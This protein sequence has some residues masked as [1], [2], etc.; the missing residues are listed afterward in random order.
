MLDAALIKECSDRSLKPA[1]VEQFINAAGSK[2]PLA[3]TVKAGS[4]LILFPK[5]KT[6]EEALGIIRENVGHAVVR[7]GLTQLPAGVGLNDPAQLQ[8]DLV[9]PCKNLKV[10]TAMF[11]KVLRIVAKWYG[12]PRDD[13][14]PQVFEDAIYAWRS[15]RF[16][17]DNVFQAE[18]VAGDAQVSPSV[19]RS[20]EEEAGASS[21]NT[22]ER[23]AFAYPENAEMRIDIS[24]INGRE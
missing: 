16:E 17:G 18:D 15:G 9:D 12:N 5:P 20:E 21:S 2:D 8:S 24:R 14:F 3:V 4:R 22:S 1:I 23:E 11:A 10:G 19:G 13:V 7:V 6:A